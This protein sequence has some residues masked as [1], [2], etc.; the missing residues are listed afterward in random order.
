MPACSFGPPRD[1]IEEAPTR[2]KESRLAIL[3]L[4]GIVPTPDEKRSLLLESWTRKRRRAVG[5]ASASFDQ[6]YAAAAPKTR[7]FIDACGFAPDERLL[8]PG[9]FDQVILLSGR[10]FEADE[11]GRSYRLKPDTRSIWVRNA[12]IGGGLNKGPLL[13]P[14]T[15]KARAAAEAIDA[16]VESG[17][18]QIAN[19]WGLRGAEPD[20][21]ASI[22]G[23]VLGDSFMQGMF[24]GEAETPVVALEKSLER[25]L[26]RD[27]SILNTGLAGYATEQYYYT[28]LEYAKR[29]EP[30]FVVLSVYANDFGPEALTGGGDWDAAAFWVSEIECECWNR[31]IILVIAP[32]PQETQVERARREYHYPARLTIA[33]DTPAARYCNPLDDFIDAH[34]RLMLTGTLRPTSSLLFNGSIGDQHF[35]AAGASVWAACLGRRLTLLLKQKNATAAAVRAAKKAKIK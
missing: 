18:V 35:S 1:R 5:Q 23:I 12:D 10:V 4:I 31:G 32:A 16:V 26:G 25:S 21:N 30:A 28:L 20:R 14:D 7:A 6:I 9:D 15:P 11:T 24:L 3:K 27:V 29:F 34:I 22:R 8:R 2:L 17:S 33:I 19:S 13:I